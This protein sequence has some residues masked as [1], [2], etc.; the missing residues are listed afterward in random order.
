MLRAKE[1]F[2]FAEVSEMLARAPDVKSP[3]S[4]ASIYFILPYYTVLELFTLKIVIDGEVIPQ[5]S[6][7][8]ICCHSELHPSSSFIGLH[9]PY[10]H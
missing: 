7:R 2:Y 8:S 4:R 3:T 5:L 6:S 1:D 10:P 9:P